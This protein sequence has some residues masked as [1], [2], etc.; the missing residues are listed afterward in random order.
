MAENSL[1]QSEKEAKTDARLVERALRAGWLTPE[2]RA[3]LQQQVYSLAQVCEQ[4]KDVEGFTPL[5]ALL[6]KM[7]EFD[8]R[9]AEREEAREAKTLPAKRKSVGV[10]TFEE[11]R[12]EL[13]KR[14]AGQ[15]TGSDDTG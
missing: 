2:R 1:F 10:G 14:I 4:T 7:Y 13:A 11:Q 3:E 15:S 12:A 9:L 5:A 8:L 6:E